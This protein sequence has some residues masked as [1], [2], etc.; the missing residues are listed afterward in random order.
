MIKV[1]IL[2]KKYFSNHKWKGF[3]FK[4]VSKSEAAN[5][6]NT[7]M[8]LMETIQITMYEAE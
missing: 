6:S 1:F 8:Q 5:I 7:K 4:Y 2:T 3:L